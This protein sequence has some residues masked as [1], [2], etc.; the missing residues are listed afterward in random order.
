[1]KLA[2]F[3]SLGNYPL[4]LYYEPASEAHTD[5]VRMTEY[6]DI[7][8]P[9]RDIREVVPAQVAIIDSKIA[10]VTEEFGKKLAML[11]EAKE[12]LLAITDQ[13]EPA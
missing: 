1:M 7:E 13:R 8:F 2:Q 9:P 5:M 3:K 6:V 12:N 4:T 11:K 10:E